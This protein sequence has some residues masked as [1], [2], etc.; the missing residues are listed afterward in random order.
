[1]MGVAWASRS[2]QPPRLSV[3]LHRHDR[4]GDHQCQGQGVAPC[5]AEFGHV[6]EVHAVDSAQAE[7]L[8]LV[9]LNKI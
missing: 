1:M 6:L 3:V 5:L 8:T 9:G 4:S 2:L 7:A